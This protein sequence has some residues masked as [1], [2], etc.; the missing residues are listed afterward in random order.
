ME[1]DDAA[2]QTPKLHSISNADVVGL[3][4]ISPPSPQ[5]AVVLVGLVLG[6]K[7]DRPLAFVAVVDEDGRID[8]WTATH[9]VAELFDRRLVAMKAIAGRFRLD[10]ARS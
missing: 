9:F 8:L 7:C 1:I 4:K 5:A 10:V 3:T 6:H 2:R